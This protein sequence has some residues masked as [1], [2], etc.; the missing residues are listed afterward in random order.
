MNASKL[1]ILFLGT[2]TIA[3]ESLGIA[4]RRPP[5]STDDILK[6]YFSDAVNK[7]RF[8]NLLAFPRPKWI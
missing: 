7:I 4:F 8:I 5:P 6:L 3:N 1:S 2:T